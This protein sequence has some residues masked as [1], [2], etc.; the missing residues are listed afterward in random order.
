MST[1]TAE[2]EESLDALEVRAEK[3]KKSA[4]AAAGLGLGQKAFLLFLIFIIYVFLHSDMFLDS[5]AGIWTGSSD[6]SGMT[7][8]GIYV[9]AL[10]CV[11]L[12][13]A[14]YTLIEYG[15]I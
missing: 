5:A 1:S 6:A 14:A 11:L 9:T 13:A 10:L 15:L 8:K 2:T 3:K 12:V 4:K 7:G